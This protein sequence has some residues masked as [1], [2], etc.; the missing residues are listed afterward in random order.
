MKSVF[1]RKIK[2]TLASSLADLPAFTESRQQFVEL[3]QQFVELRQQFVE[4][5]QQFGDLQLQLVHLQEGLL[6][7]QFDHSSR[8]RILN[9][10]AAISQSVQLLL[11]QK[12]RDLLDN[13]LALPELTDTEFRCFSQNGEDGILLYIFSI[14]GTTNKRVVEIGAGDGI[15][16]NSANLIINHGWQ[17]LL[18]DCGERTSPEAR[19]STLSVKILL[20]ILRLR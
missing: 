5:R 17:G 13:H 18:F 9:E 12:Y 19:S 11:R 6:A 10:T 20:L 2:S 7:N 3:R 4:F 8:R 1:T 16:C 15:E 14:L